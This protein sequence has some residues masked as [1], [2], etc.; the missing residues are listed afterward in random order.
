[1]SGVTRARAWGL[2]LLCLVAWVP[3]AAAQ[4]AFPIAIVD[5]QAILRDSTAARVIKELIEERRAAYQEQVSGEEKRL[6]EVEQELSQQRASMPPDAYQQRVREFQGQ[7][8]DVQRR[9]Q[10]RKRALDEAFAKAMK[11]VRDALVSVVAEIADEDGIKVVLSNSQ[12]VIAE[13]ALDI[14]SEALSRL[15][16]RLPTVDVDL[17]PIDQ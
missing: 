14:S 11:R 6:R 8:A 12:I 17:P 16:E 2:L 4:S 10:L 5:V 3:A 15:N 1:M 13:R 9:V 7:V